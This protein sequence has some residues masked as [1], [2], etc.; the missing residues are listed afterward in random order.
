MAQ[1]NDKKYTYDGIYEMLLKSDLNPEFI[2]VISTRFN[3]MAQAMVNAVKTP[4]KTMKMFDTHGDIWQEEHNRVVTEYQR[5][6]N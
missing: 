3:A 4:E 1:H 2:S 6:Y 5:Y